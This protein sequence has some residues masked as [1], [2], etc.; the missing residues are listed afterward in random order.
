LEREI[1]DSDLS[2]IAEKYSCP[3]FLTSAKTGEAVSEA[4]RS[5]VEILIEKH[6]SSK[7]G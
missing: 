5:L 6:D 3:F 4:I 7:S 1:S 2:M